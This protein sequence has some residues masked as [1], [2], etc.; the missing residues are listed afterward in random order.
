MDPAADVSAVRAITFDC[1]GTLV[2]WETGIV[3][4]VAPLL[5]RAARAGKVVRP[6][7][8]LR[9]W[10][11]IQF[12]MLSPWRPYAEILADSFALTMRALEL[13]SFADGGPGLARSLAEWPLFPDTSSSLRRLA[14]RRRL[15]IVSNIDRALL[16]ETL[17]RL[18]AP[19][20]MAAT[21]EE[22]RAYKPDPAPFHL[23]L[24]RLGLSP[25]EV[26]HV[27]FGWKY[28]LGPARAL[29]MRTCFVA[30][31]TVTE[32]PAEVDADLRVASLAEL[33]DR[34]G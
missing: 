25:S 27:A 3:G 4:Y 14:R 34:L 10:E 18:M 15:G 33:A 11:P 23:A 7:E 13:E 16:A 21:A 20:S 6:P 29:G 5:E 9:A 17:G 32:V 24:E 1:Y 22:A 26:L 31:P 28:D 2:D 12:A 19:L 8:W 30:R